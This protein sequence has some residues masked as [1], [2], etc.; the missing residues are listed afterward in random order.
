MNNTGH[1]KT[2]ANRPITVVERGLLSSGETFTGLA[3]AY[4]LTADGQPRSLDVCSHLRRRHESRT[5]VI[6]VYRS[7]QSINDNY[8][9]RTSVV[10]VLWWVGWKRQM[11]VTMRER[12]RQRDELW[13]WKNNKQ[14]WMG[15]TGPQTQNAYFLVSLRRNINQAPWEQL[16]PCFN[17][18]TTER[19]EK[20]RP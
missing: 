6:W 8:W 5:G 11:R 10:V 3:S 20:R 1:Y 12:H 15:V 19:R 14:N 9:A 4:C 18:Q 17:Y 7:C 16:G 13:R 2:L